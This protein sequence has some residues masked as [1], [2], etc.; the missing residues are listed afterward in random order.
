MNENEHGVKA[1]LS[2]SRNRFFDFGWILGVGGLQKEKPCVTKSGLAS[3]LASG[4]AR[5]PLASPDLPL[6]YPWA[7][8]YARSLACQ[9]VPRPPAHVRHLPLAWT[10]DP[11]PAMQVQVQ[12]HKRFGGWVVGRMRGWV[13]WV[14]GPFCTRVPSSPRTIVSGTTTYVVSPSSHAP[15]F[16][17]CFLS[18]RICLRKCIK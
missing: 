10:H 18:G 8:F 2:F 7:R 15:I 14:G 11:P 5:S 1:K 17:P 4:L 6:A 9:F 16:Q 3:C 12:V 13:G